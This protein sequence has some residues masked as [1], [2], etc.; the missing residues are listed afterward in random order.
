[1]YHL[2]F[3]YFL[4]WGG[5]LFFILFGAVVPVLVLSISS[6]EMFMIKCSELLSSCARLS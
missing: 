6:T 4:A 3:N 1:M 5:A 2:Y